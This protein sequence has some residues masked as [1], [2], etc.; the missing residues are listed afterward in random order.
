MK[1]PDEFALQ[2][3]QAATKPKQIVTYWHPQYGYV[4]RDVI[5][6]NRYDTSKRKFID[7]IPEKW[8][9]LEQ[10]SV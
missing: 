5:Y 7:K 3:L 6:L 2:R 10:T 4:G 1:G 9:D 8:T